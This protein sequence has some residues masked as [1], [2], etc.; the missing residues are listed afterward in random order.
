MVAQTARNNIETSFKSYIDLCNEMQYF[1]SKFEDSGQLLKF[2]IYQ[3]NS[4]EVIKCY[5]KLGPNALHFKERQLYKPLEIRD[6]S[7]QR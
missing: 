1:M 3:Q 2:S 5:R 7:I 6:V 4:P